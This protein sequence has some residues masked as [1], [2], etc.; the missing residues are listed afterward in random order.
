MFDAIRETSDPLVTP[1]ELNEKLAREM[2]DKSV[3]DLRDLTIDAEEG[4][5]LRQY[6]TPSEINFVL[7][8]LKDAD[9]SLQRK[10][11]KQQWKDERMMQTS[12]WGCS[13]CENCD[14]R[15]S[16]PSLIPSRIVLVNV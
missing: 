12:Y 13:E 6:L 1:K 4:V 15:Y 16:S 14:E 8:T 3:N 5:Q 7:K 11:R 10:G 9:N 2:L